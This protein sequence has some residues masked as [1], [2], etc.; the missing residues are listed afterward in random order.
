MRAL[1]C[2]KGTPVL[3]ACL[4]RCWLFCNPAARSLFC[5]H[6]TRAAAVIPLLHRYMRYFESTHGAA[7]EALERTKEVKEAFQ[8][9]EQR[10]LFKNL[11][12]DLYS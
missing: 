10:K 5:H 7:L 2:G 9:R 6:P 3:N 8:T 4:A 11:S 1:C 12:A